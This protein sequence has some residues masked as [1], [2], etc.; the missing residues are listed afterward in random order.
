MNRLAIVHTPG[1]TTDEVQRAAMGLGDGTETLYEWD[2][3]WLKE[4]GN[5]LPRHRGLWLW[6][7]RS[8]HVVL[9]PAYYLPGAVDVEHGCASPGQWPG[10]ERWSVVD[11]TEVLGMSDGGGVNYAERLTA[12]VHNDCEWWRE[13]VELCV[14]RCQRLGDCDGGK[15]GVRCHRACLFTTTVP[16][17]VLYTEEVTSISFL[18]SSV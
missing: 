6:L 17:G 7:C 9:C 18:C 10:M 5:A 3:G 16:S 14:Q 1:R 15:D 2:D 8:Y 4:L 13:G 11:V 12:I